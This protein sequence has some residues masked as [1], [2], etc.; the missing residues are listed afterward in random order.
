[1]FMPGMPGMKSGGDATIAT[2]RALE[3]PPG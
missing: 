1:M 2:D 3:G